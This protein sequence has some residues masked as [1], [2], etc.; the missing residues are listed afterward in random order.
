M[1]PLENQFLFHC[2]LKA[3]SLIWATI[4]VDALCSEGHVYI[5]SHTTK[6]RNI[7]QENYKSSVPR[8]SECT[9]SGSSLSPG[10]LSLDSRGT[11][12]KKTL[13]H[14][15][16]PCTTLILWQDPFQSMWRVEDKQELPYLDCHW[17]IKVTTLV[18]C[19]MGVWNEGSLLINCSV[20]ALFM[21]Y[22]E[23][24]NIERQHAILGWQN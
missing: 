7:H 4:C 9:T 2:S 8:G 17:N 3:K 10:F 16:L 18:G 24:N 1:R 6:A 20:T 22:R 14:I 21:Q 5:I 13:Q 19:S 23:Q 11:W 15:L 12:H